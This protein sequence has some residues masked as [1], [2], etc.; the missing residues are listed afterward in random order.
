MNRGGDDS[1]PVRS[2]LLRDA[3]TSRP[4][5][6]SCSATTSKP[7]AHLRHEPGSSRRESALIFSRDKVSG[8]TSAATRFMEAERKPRISTLSSG[9]HGP[10]GRQG[11]RCFGVSSGGL[12]EFVFHL[13]G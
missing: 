8:L 12:E 5:P 9:H 11:F 7:D 10:E 6:Y 2:S 1:S 4:R 13:P 3:G